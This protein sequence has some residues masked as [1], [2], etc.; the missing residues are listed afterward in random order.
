MSS[1]WGSF[2]GCF[3]PRLVCLEHLTVL[4]YIS[5]TMTRC[6]TFLYHNFHTIVQYPEMKS[7]HLTRVQWEKVE[8]ERMRSHKTASR[9]RKEHGPMHARSQSYEDT[10]DAPSKMHKRDDICPRGPQSSSL[11]VYSRQPYIVKWENLNCSF[12]VNTTS[13]NESRKSCRYESNV[14]LNFTM[15]LKTV[16]QHSHLRKFIKGSNQGYFCSYIFMWL[17]KVIGETTHSSQHIYGN[18]WMSSNLHIYHQQFIA[19][20]ITNLKLI[21]KKACQFY[22]RKNESSWHCIKPRRPFLTM[23]LRSKSR[24]QVFNRERT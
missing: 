2:H 24:T 16:K 9:P 4:W 13:C 14:P 20:Y 19:Q 1:A 10:R 21:K 6:L 17:T 23:N 11:L 7:I 22:Q 15:L 3:L 8:K 12:T 5:V 18:I